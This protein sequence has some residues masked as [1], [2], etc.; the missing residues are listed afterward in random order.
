MLKRP[1]PE[2]VRPLRPTAFHVLLALAG[3]ERHG[4]AIKQEVERL[5]EGAV[6]MG[7]GTLYETLQ[8]LEEEELIREMREKP[9]GEPDHVQRKYYR[10]TARGRRLLESEARRLGRIADYARAKIEEAT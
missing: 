4:Y 10:L 5:T 7:P 8:K 6:A 9:E 3:G 2:P 1:D